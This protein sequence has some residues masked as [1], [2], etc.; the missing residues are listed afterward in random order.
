[1]RDAYGVSFAG[2]VRS[3][4]TGIFP[5]IASNSYSI[6]DVE[7]SRGRCY[8]QERSARVRH[9]AVSFG[10]ESRNNRREAND[11]RGPRW[12]GGFRSVAR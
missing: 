5:A 4:V 10:S 12:T 6:A 11:P 1:M 8:N 2:P 3:A 7:G 9:G